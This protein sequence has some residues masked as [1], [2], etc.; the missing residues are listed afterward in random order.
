VHKG[1]AKFNYEKAKWFNHE[2]IK[3]LSAEE[4]LP[5]VKKSFEERE[6]PVGD[7]RLLHSVIELVR[8]RCTLIPDFYTQAKFFF[9]AP[10]Q[11]DLNAIKPKW[12]DQKT[13][14]FRQ[15]T[16]VLKQLPEW[17]AISLEASFKELASAKNIKPGELQLPLRIMLVGG[18]MGPPVFEIASTLGKEQTITR[19][20]RLLDQIGKA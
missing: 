11:W 5:L 2:W 20:E 14:F 17:N 4:L 19:I 10:L 16:G 6:L 15:F 13:D 8:E 9:E 1:G 12:N 18:K 3:R 7:D